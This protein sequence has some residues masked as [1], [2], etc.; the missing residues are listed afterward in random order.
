MQTIPYPGADGWAVSSVTGADPGPS[1]KGAKRQ[2]LFSA[3]VI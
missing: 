2:D 3:G 1:Q